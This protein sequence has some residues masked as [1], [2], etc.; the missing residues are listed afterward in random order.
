[1][2]LEIIG[3]RGKSRL[4][5]VFRGNDFI[6]KLKSRIFKSQGKKNS[7]N[8]N[9]QF[10]RQNNQPK[11]L[12]TNNFMDEKLSNIHNNPVDA[13]I[14]RRPEDYLLSSARDYFGEKGLIDIEYIE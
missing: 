9:Y 1:M 4:Y 3:V 13:D 11:E 8:T 5:R 10:W 14:V 6:L 2:L 12:M 7:K